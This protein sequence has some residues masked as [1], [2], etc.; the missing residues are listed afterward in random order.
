[1]GANAI[2]ENQNKNKKKTKRKRKKN[3]YAQYAALICIRKVY[4]E[5]L[6]HT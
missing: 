5:P 4:Y 6:R 3:M 1:M 2:F